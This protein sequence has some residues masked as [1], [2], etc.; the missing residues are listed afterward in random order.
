MIPANAVDRYHSQRRRRSPPAVSLVRRW[1]VNVLCTVDVMRSLPWAARIARVMAPV[2]AAHLRKNLRTLAAGLDGRRFDVTAGAREL[3]ARKCMTSLLTA[4][5]RRSGWGVL[6]RIVATDRIAPLLPYRECRTPT[7]M[8][9]WHV[10]P[11][12]GL[13]TVFAHLQIP[14]TGVIRR[15]Y[16]WPHDA[17]NERV[18]TTGGADAKASVL[19]TAL[20]RLREGRLLVIAV[21]GI[22]GVRLP[23]VACLGR[24]VQFARGP[25]ML[26][27]LSAARIVP[28]VP[29]WAPAGR[30]GV[31]VGDP[32]DLTRAPGLTDEEY[33]TALAARAA[34]WYEEYIVA[35]IEELRPATL[36]I[37][38]DYCPR[39]T[40]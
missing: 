3:F 34:R 28:I 20:K 37:L 7:V 32:I 35:S 38:L 16:G 26:A 13:A 23:P 15:D 1:L 36:R 40:A 25:F 2:Y 11:P 22:E 5:T 8:V 6:H 29:R 30:V 31:V 21:D 17:A 27:R 14:S 39:L 19:W 33:E 18:Y 9:T 10:G 12:F 24:Q 4:Y